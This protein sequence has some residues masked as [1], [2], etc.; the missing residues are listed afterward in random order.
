MSMWSPASGAAFVP[1]R[2]SQQTFRGAEKKALW[3]SFSMEPS[4]GTCQYMCRNSHHLSVVAPA[5]RETP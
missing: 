4:W 5:K 3:A 1:G 2:P